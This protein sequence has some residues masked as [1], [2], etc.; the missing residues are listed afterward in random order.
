V[1]F[2]ASMGRSGSTILDSILGQVS[3]FVSVGE[4]KFIWERGLREN[5]R[6]GCGE[7]FRSCPFWTQVFD[8]AFG[9]MDAVDVD[10]SIA[11]LNTTR[12][13]HFPSMM[14]PGSGKRYSRRHPGYLRDLGRL[15]RAVAKVSGCSVIVD[16]SK[17]PSHAF[18]LGLIDDLDVRILHVTRD[19]R[20]VAH[21]W[22]QVKFDPDRDVPVAMPRQPAWLTA[23]YWSFWNITIEAL[24]RKAHRPYRLLRYED[25]MND[26]EPRAREVL[27]FAGQPN[28]NLPF[29]GRHEVR[30]GENH[31]V[32]GNPIRFDTGTVQLR[33][34]ERWRTQMSKLAAVATNLIT[35]PVRVRLGYPLPDSSRPN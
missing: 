24:A 9:G 32:S 1:L 5:R 12:T 13:R 18:V 31:T 25:L 14:M 17:Y 6:C 7:Y 4:I 22:A 33:A 8:E 27:E 23:I 20:A 34:D 28:G 15:Y 10:E 29:A 3:A 30:L 11:A 35:W 26:P 19:P 16:S 21:S 2:I